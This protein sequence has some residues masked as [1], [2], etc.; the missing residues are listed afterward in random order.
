MVVIR[1]TDRPT[2]YHAFTLGLGPG[3]KGPAFMV[4]IRVADRSNI[5]HACTLG[6][7]PGPKGPALMLVWTSGKVCATSSQA[8]V[9]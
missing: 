7:G 3:P 9:Q 8:Q 4:V 2:I 1:I 5:R 6:L